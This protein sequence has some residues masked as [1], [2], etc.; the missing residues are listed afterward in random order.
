VF[1]W[2][3]LIFYVQVTLQA[4]LTQTK[5]KLIIGSR[6]QFMIVKL[7]QRII[8]LFKFIL[9]ISLFPGI[10]VHAFAR[11]KRI[12][13]LNVTLLEPIGSD[14]DIIKSVEDASNETS[15]CFVVHHCAVHG[16]P[17]V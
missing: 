4:R 3:L 5:G 10:Q 1:F 15:H 17:Q 16:I 8:E 6:E 7:K 14:Y 13:Q 2:N 9:M 12:I 11:N